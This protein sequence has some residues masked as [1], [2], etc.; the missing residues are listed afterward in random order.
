MN[1]LGFL[2]PAYYTAKSFTIKNV[3][4]ILMGVGTGCSVS[5]VISAAN[6]APE[7]ARQVEDAKYDKTAKVHGMTIKEVIAKY[8]NGDIRLEKLTV[9]EW[10]KAVAKYFGPAAALE[11]LALISFWGAH[12]IDIHRQAIL[13]GVATTAEEAL[14][15]YQKKV[16]ELIGDKAENEVQTAIAQ[17]KIDKCPPPEGSVILADDAEMW[18]LIG[19]PPQRFKATYSHIKDTQNEINWEMLQH[20][21]ASESDLFWLLDS[22][23]KYLKPEWDSGSVGWSCDKLLVLDIAV[24]FDPDHKPV[25]VITYKDKDGFRYDPQPGYSKGL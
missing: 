6:N 10:I 22:D 2:K 9:W 20:M 19:Q 14:R 25:G 24:G 3:S 4:H 8:T 1:V 23:K 12:G 5:A 21:Y 17:D 13:V 11:L 16:K 18:W 15:E 7:A